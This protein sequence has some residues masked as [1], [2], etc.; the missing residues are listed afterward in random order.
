MLSVRRLAAIA[1]AALVMVVS[2][3]EEKPNVLVLSGD[4]GG[5]GHFPF[6]EAL[7]E[8]GLFYSTC[9]APSSASKS[10]ASWLTGCHELRAGVIEESGGRRFIRPDTPLLS[11]AFRTAGYDTAFLGVWGLG[12]SPPFRPED[13]GFQD[14]WVVGTGKTGDYWDAEGQDTWLRSKT[15]WSS[16]PGSM[17]EVMTTELKKWLRNRGGEKRPFFT[18]VNLP[19]GEER[20]MADLVEELG[21]HGLGENT[22]VVVLGTVGRSTEHS[23]DPMVPL[24]FR[25]SGRLSPGIAIT[26]PVSIQDGLPTLLNLCGVKPFRDWSFDGVD[27]APLE[28]KEPQDERTYFFHP[29]SWPADQSP[30]R[31]K[32][33]GFAVRKGNFRLS[34]LELIDLGRPVNERINL[35]EA[36]PDLG[37]EMMRE[38]GIWW[39]NLR[40]SLEP[41][42]IIV[43]DGRQPKVFLTPND[44]WPGRESLQAKT[45]I[46]NQ[47][48]VRSILKALADPEQAASVP[49][50]GGIWKVHASREGHYQF[51]LRK[52]PPT[53][54]EVEAK[55]FAQ[56]RAGSAHIRAGKSEVK[57]QLLQ[58]ATSIA[59]GLDLPEG[60]SDVEAWFTGQAGIERILGAFF[61]T[62][63]WVGERKLPDPNWKATEVP[64]K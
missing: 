41:S 58:G 38:Y 5:G 45:D 18:H 32:S 12:E 64:E 54:S 36:E 7:K 30:E 47:E 28:G 61:V 4:F 3:V 52:L 24:I 26:T 43:G 56:L 49:A 31:Y 11:E 19:Q 62:V 46:R 60:Q 22:I 9:F 27:L 2:G 53:A 50:L 44:W 15:G 55:A 59:M 17:R 51:T 33:Q 14:V 35:F 10:L 25:W 63:E 20:L 13:R 29:G 16:Y 21:S 39:Q 57:A 8:E 1:N 37:D 34:G 23:P 40:K 6:V 48:E 42:R